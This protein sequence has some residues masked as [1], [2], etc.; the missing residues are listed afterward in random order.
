MT[1]FTAKQ[2]IAI[3]HAISAGRTIPFRIVGSKKTG[4]YY[5]TKSELLSIE[6]AISAGD[7]ATGPF[8][9]ATEAVLDAL[10]L[11]GAWSEQP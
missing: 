3:E 1:H 9:T 8:G 5:S 7:D 11:L 4:Y 2:I 6:C 10:E